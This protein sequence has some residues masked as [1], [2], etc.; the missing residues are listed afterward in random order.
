MR[1]VLF[2]GYAGVGKDTAAQ[3]LIE[4]GWTRMAFA[5]PLKEA[6]YRLNPVVWVSVRSYSHLQPIIDTHGWDWAKRHT[7]VRT[8]LQSM[9]TEVGRELFGPDFWV[10]LLFT[11]ADRQGIEKLVITDGRFANEVEAVRDLGGRVIHIA[12]PGVGPVNDHVS[13]AGVNALPFDLL[14]SNDGTIEELHT[15]V[16]KAVKWKWGLL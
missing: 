2:T 5:D 12:R 3:P 13:D 10:E 6:V 8:L 9:G 16:R 14:L 15:K 1:V 7:D 4:E 11:Q